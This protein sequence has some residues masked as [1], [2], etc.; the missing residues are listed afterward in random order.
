MNVVDTNWY[1]LDEVS[2]FAR[3]G[4]EL[5]LNDIQQYLV[6]QDI[7]QLRIKSEVW[8][9]SDIGAGSDVLRQSV[10]EVITDLSY[11]IEQM[12]QALRILVA[13]KQG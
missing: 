9:K 10:S 3:S 6:F 5:D 1:I 11:V 13:R 8:N 7:V 12:R 4:Y 2:G